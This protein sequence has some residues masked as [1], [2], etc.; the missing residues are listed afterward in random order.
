MTATAATPPRT[1]APPDRGQ[2][3]RGDAALPAGDRLVLFAALLA[4]LPMQRKE[5]S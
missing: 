2:R 4:W 1:T 3:F 5:S